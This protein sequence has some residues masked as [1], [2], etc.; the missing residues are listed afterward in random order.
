MVKCGDMLI[1]VFFFFSSRRRNTRFKCDW[2]SDVCSSDLRCTPP[3]RKCP[4]WSW[5]RCGGDWARGSRGC[6]PPR[7]VATGIGRAACRGR[8]E[9]SGVARSLKKKKRGE[10]NAKRG[11]TETQSTD[12]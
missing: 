4:Q 11:G 5:R 10:K 3:P 7:A 6:T 8:G 12:R 1:V 9:I 2:S